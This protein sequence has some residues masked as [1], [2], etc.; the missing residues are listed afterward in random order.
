VKAPSLAVVL[1]TDVA[2]TIG[3][4]LDALRAQTIA[5]EL[6]VVVVSA[7]ELELPASG[8]LAAIRTVR[9]PAGA[10]LEQGRAAGVLAAQAPVVFVGETHA[11]PAPDFAAAIVAAHGNG[12]TGVV[13]AMANANP[14]TISWSNLV[15][16]YGRW[17]A[18]QAGGEALY[19]P[20]TNCSYR[21]TVLAAYGEQLG[22]VLSL[23]GALGADLRRA[24]HRCTVEPG[25]RL[26]HL[27]VATLRDWLPERYLAG[28]IL[29]GARA[30]RWRR[31]RR[32]L[33]AAGILLVPPLHLWRA[34]RAIRRLERPL[35]KLALL[36]PALA[37][38]SLAW[39]AGELAGY[40]RGT[41]S[42]SERMVP[43]ELHKARYAPRRR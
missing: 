40:L 43:Y 24:G 28:R 33:Y 22:E 26:D 10:T 9:C 23:R 21:R 25:A 35:L 38:G 20:E 34:A 5:A 17:V 14:G 2:E 12:A 7:G 27:N 13:P 29:G 36:A 39:T 6:E 1:V 4:V 42:A 3:E 8:R 37:V 32:L 41:G 16:D 18:P 11:F 31:R 19:F 30:A 15:L